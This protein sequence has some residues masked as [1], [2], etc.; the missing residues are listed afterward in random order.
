MY[1]F[2]PEHDLALANGDI[3]FVPPESALRFGRDC[4]SLTKFMRGLDSLADLDGEDTAK[5]MVRKIVPWGWN[6]LLCDRLLKEGY[7]RSLLP[8]SEELESIRRLSHRRVA[9]DGLAELDGLFD[10]FY[11]DESGECS[12]KNDKRCKVIGSSYRIAASSL[13]EVVNFINQNKNVVLK[14]PLSGSGKGIR[15]VSGELSHSDS[16]WCRNNI[17]RYGY[18]VVEKRFAPVL[19][20]AML[21][22]CEAGEVQFLGYSLFYASNGAYRGNLLASND[23][24]KKLILIYLPKELLDGIKGEVAGYIGRKIAPWYN[25]FVGVDQFV[26]S[27]FTGYRGDNPVNGPMENGADGVADYYFNPM[28]E[29]NLRMTMGLV[30]RNIFD[31]FS[32][33]YNLR[34]G[35]HTFEICRNAGQSGGYS[36][37]LEECGGMLDFS[38]FSPFSCI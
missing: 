25:G 21:F 36:Y 16:G 2:N 38:A 37:S 1:I 13:D 28:V 19:E 35:S 27:D 30:A 33:E 5:G 26:C 24:L 18:V 12:G 3:H 8:D 34:D 20:C 23:F 31:N 32:A 29:I 7:S 9:L 11:D 14:S 4:A 17:S 15:F 10:H 6:S 22:R